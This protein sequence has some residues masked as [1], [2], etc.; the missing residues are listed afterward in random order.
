[1]SNNT[2]DNTNAISYSQPADKILYHNHQSDEIN[3]HIKAHKTA[4]E[5]LIFNELK[6]QTNDDGIIIFLKT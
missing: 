5:T 1:M 6:T 2:D 3:S 4:K